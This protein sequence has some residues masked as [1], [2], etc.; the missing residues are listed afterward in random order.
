MYGDRHCH[1]RTPSTPSLVNAAIAAGGDDGYSAV[2]AAAVEGDHV[3]IRS[4]AG[5][6]HRGKGAGGGENGREP[7]HESARRGHLEAVRLLLERGADVD[8]VDEVPCFC[9]A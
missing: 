7:L 6:V 1:P 4:L 2:L 3:A 8:A 5:A 9:S